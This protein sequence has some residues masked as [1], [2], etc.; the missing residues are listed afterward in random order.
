MRGVAAFALDCH[1]DGHSST[2]LEHEQ[3]TK[4]VYWL[5]AESPSV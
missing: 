1:D 2:A 4:L 3:Q 5:P